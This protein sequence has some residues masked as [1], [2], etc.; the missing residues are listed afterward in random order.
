M[1]KEK[2]K[3]INTPN[4]KSKVEHKFIFGNVKLN[5]LK[6]LNV[7]GL[8]I[9]E[10]NHCSS[11]EG[12][13]RKVVAAA[14]SIRKCLWLTDPV[15]MLCGR[16]TKVNLL[17]R[18]KK[19]KKWEREREG[20]KERGREGRREEGERKGKEEMEGGREAERKRGCEC[21]NKITI[22]KQ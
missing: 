17:I 13:R 19:G 3:L 4:R 6:L 9:D 2:E 1:K 10:L 16:V 15:T 7:I 14:T 12:R 8:G 21:W 5:H 22:H 11:W 18:K 20:R